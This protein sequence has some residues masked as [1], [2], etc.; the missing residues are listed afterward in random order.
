M[1]TFSD[2][3]IETGHFSMHMS[4]Q[5]LEVGETDPKSSLASQCPPNQAVVQ[6]E[7]PS[8]SNRLK[9]NREVS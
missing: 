7:T 8:Q 3:I 6:S 4:P 2:L 9:E 5:H 1:E